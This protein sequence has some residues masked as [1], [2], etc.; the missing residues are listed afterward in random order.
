MSHAQPTMPNARPAS[1][2]SDA[3]NQEAKRLEKLQAHSSSHRTAGTHEAPRQPTAG[4]LKQLETERG[5]G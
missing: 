4:I 5:D 2:K 3:E 1:T